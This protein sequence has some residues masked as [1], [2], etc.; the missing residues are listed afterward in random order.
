MDEGSHVLLFQRQT[1][2]SSGAGGITK[3]DHNIRL[4]QHG[5]A[6]PLFD[7]P[8][9]A[10]QGKG[11]GAWPTCGLF[12]LSGVCEEAE[13]A[14]EEADGPYQMGLGLARPP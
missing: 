7:V 4:R 6:H 13:R 11:R 3:S 10:T 2:L 12:P 1:E 5:R 8:V 14:V 9:W